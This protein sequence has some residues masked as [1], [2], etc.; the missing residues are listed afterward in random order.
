MA[1]SRE[2]SYPLII[3]DSTDMGIDDDSV[4]TFWMSFAGDSTRSLNSVLE[5]NSSERLVEFDYPQSQLL[6]NAKIQ[7]PRMPRRKG[8]IITDAGLRMPRRRSTKSSISSLS[9]EYRRNLSTD[10]TL[11]EYVRTRMQREAKDLK[12]EE[13]VPPPLTE[14]SRQ[15][16]LERFQEEPKSR[17]SLEP[18]MLPKRREDTFLDE[19]EPDEDATAPLTGLVRRV[20]LERFQEEP[21]PRGSLEL[22]ALPQRK[23]SIFSIS[24][25]DDRIDISKLLSS[26]EED[27]DDI[28][29]PKV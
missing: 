21:H 15:E 27:I 19:D 18:P 23:G 26:L 9:A 11:K 6:Q 14:L 17:T 4:I 28:F 16:S 5:D 3:C 29:E 13:E 1:L 20:S 8:S 2:D 25:E 10:S 7:I 22:P 24:S 12:E